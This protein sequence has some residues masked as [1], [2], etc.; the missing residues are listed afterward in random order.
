MRPCR[1]DMRVS[2][3]FE[4]ILV[5]RPFHE[6]LDTHTRLIGLSLIRHHHPTFSLTFQCSFSYKVC[7]LVGYTCKPFCEFALVHLLGSDGA[8]FPKPYLTINITRLELL[9]YRCSQKLLLAA[10]V[11]IT[12]ATYCRLRPES[13]RL[14]YLE[15]SVEEYRRYRGRPSVGNLSANYFKVAGS[16]RTKGSLL[17]P[18]KQSSRLFSIMGDKTAN[19]SQI[20]SIHA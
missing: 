11:E 10:L 15:A 13:C 1:C 17:K 14:L 12:F 7:N 16:K 20:T 4:R 18:K 3:H 19:Y 5:D 9:S 8:G 2:Q 6:T